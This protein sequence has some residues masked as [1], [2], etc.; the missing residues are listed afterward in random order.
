MRD[1]ICKDKDTRRVKSD[2]E[3]D[4]LFRR[5]YTKHVYFDGVLGMLVAGFCLKTVEACLK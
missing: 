2:E 5:K 3:L 4:E 1:C